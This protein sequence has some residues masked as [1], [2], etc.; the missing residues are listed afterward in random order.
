[1]GF[2][3]INIDTVLKKIRQVTME[4]S[5]WHYS[6]SLLIDV[7]HSDLDRVMHMIHF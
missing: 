5:C 4:T 3:F 1:M 7:N 2:F 6:M